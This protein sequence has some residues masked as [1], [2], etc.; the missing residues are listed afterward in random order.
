MGLRAVRQIGFLCLTASPRL[1]LH[2]LRIAS[3]GS[4]GVLRL[5]MGVGVSRALAGG[6]ELLLARYGDART[7]EKYGK[8]TEIGRAGARLEG[9][10]ARSQPVAKRPTL[11]VA[12]SAGKGNWAGIPWIAFL[13]RRETATTRRGVYC[14]YL[15]REDMSGVYLTFM[16]GVT[17]ATGSRGRKEGRRYL[18]EN[19]GELRSKAASLAAS[20]FS[21]DDDIDLRTDTS[22]GRDYEHSTIAYKFYARDE[23]P[24]DE[25]LL[26]DL[27]ACLSAYDG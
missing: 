26:Q 7:H 5:L 1:A 9:E 11:R 23:V 20:G 13:D 18:R 16:Q 21:L 10:F 25:V 4:H 6:L 14:V 12:F 17:E 27:E 19:A 22:L 15:F 24:D 3:S 2:A 8:D